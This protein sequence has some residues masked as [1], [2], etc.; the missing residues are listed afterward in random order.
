MA[1]LGRRLKVSRERARGI[2]LAERAQRK[3][4]EIMAEAGI[5]AELLPEPARK[6][7]ATAAEGGSVEARRA[8]VEAWAESNVA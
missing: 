4:L 6:E 3:T 2:C 8:A 1:E 7:A 5:P